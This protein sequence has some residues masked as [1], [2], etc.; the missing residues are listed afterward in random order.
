[1]RLEES[2]SGYVAGVLEG[3]RDHL[4]QCEIQDG[5]AMTGKQQQQVLQFSNGRAVLQQQ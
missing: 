5:L 3:G 1:M 2:C 4:V